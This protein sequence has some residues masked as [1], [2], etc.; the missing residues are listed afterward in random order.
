MHKYSPAR[1]VVILLCPS[2]LRWSLWCLGQCE[3]QH[4][5]WAMIQEDK[6]L[7]REVGDNKRITLNSI[8]SIKLGRK[9]HKI[10]KSCCRV[11]IY[12]VNAW[13]RKKNSAKCSPIHSYGVFS[14]GNEC[15]CYVGLCSSY[16]LPDVTFDHLFV[17]SQ[18]L[19]LIN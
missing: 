19:L 1:Y 18:L 9:W 17:H 4:T 8:Y 16:H 12:K 5:K 15:H 11:W 3:S 13:V 2:S 10:I 7:S 14:N 6:G